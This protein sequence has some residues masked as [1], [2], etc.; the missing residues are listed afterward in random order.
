[1]MKP[2]H[3]LINELNYELRIRGI[4]TTRD[5]HDKR[6]MLAKLLDKEKNRNVNI[7]DPNFDFNAEKVAI[8]A[9]L[10]NLNQQIQ[11]FEGTEND[12]AYLRVRSRL[13]HVTG[14]IQRVIV[15]DREEDTGNTLEFKNESYATCVLLEAEL[16]DRVINENGAAINNSSDPVP[17]QMPILATVPNQTRPVE[18]YK[19]DIKFD[20]TSKSLGVKEFLERVNELA[21]ARHVTK[22][23]L[24]ES[25]ADLFSGK[26]R[27][28]LRRIKN[29]DEVKDWDSLINKLERDFLVSDYDDELW[30]FIK[31]RKQ[32]EDEPVV[33]Y[34]A[35]MDSLFGRLSN[36]PAV[37]TKIKWMRT[38]LKSDY[39]KR[40]A[41]ENF[42]SVEELTNAARRVEEVYLVQSSR[43]GRN[44]ATR[45]MF[46]SD[47]AFLG[48]EAVPPNGYDMAKLSDSSF[49]N[50]KPDTNTLRYNNANTRRDFRGKGSSG[51]NSNRA[52]V[53]NHNEVSRN[54]S[55]R[56]NF[57][58]SSINTSQ[59]EVASNGTPRL[60]SNLP[61]GAKNKKTNSTIICWN[62]NQP[63]HKYQNCT[64]R[65]KKFCYKCGRP[66]V[67][68]YSC[69]CS[70]N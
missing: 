69:M 27:L 70:G 20:G 62:C 47:V 1:M 18:I 11:E 58:C 28:W 40:L 63:N 23:Q 41:L 48:I 29:S 21:E 3:L 26:A 37:S 60:N 42:N 66:N 10:D 35:V 51:K 31:T 33:I 36:T 15:P 24:Y 56:S 2:T 7:L 22:S 54:A 6:K 44:R 50:I 9:T 39:A 59:N 14:R 25:A 16:S 53:D 46:E 32:E 43:Q 8:T 34:I 17:L 65:R 12:S 30:Q 5:V 61:N 19:W 68:S 57:A 67:T 38:N 13:I 64:Q 55:N 4:E 45:N 49:V 52:S